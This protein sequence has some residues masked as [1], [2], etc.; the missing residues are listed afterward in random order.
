M[1]TPT[2]SYSEPTFFA[3][4]ESLPLFSRRFLRPPL[5]SLAG[6]GSPTLPRD[7]ADEFRAAWAVGLGLS[8]RV[9]VAERGCP[10]TPT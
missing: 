4:E 8:E 7:P 6:C 1:V 3:P 9:G 10:A 2:L 5:A